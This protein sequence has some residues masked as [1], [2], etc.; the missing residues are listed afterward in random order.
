MMIVEDGLAWNGPDIRDLKEWGFSFLL[1]GAKSGDHKYL[2]E[3]FMQANDRDEIETTT[4]DLK[5][6]GSGQTQY[7]SGLPLNAS[8]SEVK[9]N[10]LQRYEYNA[11]GDAVLR[12][13]WVTYTSDSEIKHA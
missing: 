5:L 1:V 7:A 8:Q 10:L 6:G 9:V 3:Q 4:D 2:F 11:A 12:F 13:S